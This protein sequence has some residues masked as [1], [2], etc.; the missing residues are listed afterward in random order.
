MI[1]Y[2][3]TKYDPALRDSSGA[4]LADEWTSFS[5]IGGAFAGVVLTDD[6]YRRV[7]E[8]YIDAALAFL[9]EGGVHSLTVEGIENHKGLA[10][11]LDEG[12]VL[13]LEQV[14]DV[15]R[16]ILREEFWCRL[17]CRGGFVH[18]GW[19]YYMYIGVPHHCP[20]AELLAKGL[21]LSTE[22]FSSPYKV[23]LDGEDG[24]SLGG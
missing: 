12:S 7:E 11:A 16:D 5:D 24:D 15:I 23:S 6:E 10:L 19:G 4:Y 21:G 14:G 22:E 1:E 13:S 3:V 2:R 8:A 18:C 17:E 9:R 20:E